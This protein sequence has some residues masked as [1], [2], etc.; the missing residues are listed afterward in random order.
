MGRSQVLY[1]RT[2]GR[3]RDRGGRGTPGP[4]RRDQHPPPRAQPIPDDGRQEQPANKWNASS[5]YEESL[6]L[7]STSA[8]YYETSPAPVGDIEFSKNILGSGSLDVQSL[9]AALA[10][11]S[12]SRRLR[13]PIHVADAVAGDLSSCVD[14]DGSF[15]V[16][17]RRPTKVK[18]TTDG[19]VEV[20]NK[21][22]PTIDRKDD[23]DRYTSLEE[24]VDDNIEE[25]RDRNV[26]KSTS[27]KYP[28]LS[29][30]AK[31]SARQ[32]VTEGC[33]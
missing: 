4:R 14:D 12:L 1:N 13:I 28:A 27:K 21:D 33:A 29:I 2:K 20:R 22:L 32:G 26:D 30:S 17:T 6:L 3:N 24:A 11:L 5:K 25:G 9:S 7:E 15:T 18:V 23:S 10:T 8:R 19:G 16:D 31:G